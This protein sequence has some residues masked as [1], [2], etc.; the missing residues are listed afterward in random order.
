MRKVLLSCLIGLNLFANE[1]TFLD[2]LVSEVNN[3]LDSNL[4]QKI[5]LEK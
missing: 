5:K 2:D 4:T 1:A 3:T